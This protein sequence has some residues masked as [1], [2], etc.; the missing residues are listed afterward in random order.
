MLSNNFFR[1]ALAIRCLLT[2]YIVS[3]TLLYA[4]KNIPRNG[5]DTLTKTGPA[6]VL[7]WTT[8]W[9]DTARKRDI[10]LKV[11]YPEGSGVCPVILYSHGLGGSSEIYGYLGEHWASH[12]YISIHP[13]HVGSD[14][15]L[16]LAK[17]PGE[18][19]KAAANPEEI[20]NRP[21]DLSYLLDQLALRQAAKPNAAQPF[22]LRDRMD[23]KH[24][25]A[26]GHSFG[27]HTTVMIGGAQMPLGNQKPLADSRVSAIIPMSAPVL[28]G[29]LFPRMQEKT[30][31]SMT[32]PSLHLTGTLDDS[33]VGETKAADRRVP[34]DYM[35]KS[36]RQL[37]IFD[38]GDHM[39]FSGRASLTPRPDDA[40]FQAQIAAITTI[41]WQAYLRDDKAAREWINEPKAGL[42]KFLG[43]SAKVETLPAK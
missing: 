20:R 28:G 26:A 22:P 25:G 5:L 41:F 40:Q 10:P 36:E 31:G 6:R 12:G 42:G 16:L 43:K 21:L 7:T 29:K 8:E 23:L 13:T 17:G 15:K 3:G 2:L 30:Y 32:V 33:P 18:L 1:P 37:V 4:Q 11:Y 9:H 34:F 38:K 27:A 14:T 24:V 19:V 39:I 35:L